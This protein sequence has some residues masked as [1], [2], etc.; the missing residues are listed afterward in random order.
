MKTE[1]VCLDT[2]IL[3]DYLL[4]KKEA[5]TQIQEVQKVDCAT[6]AI[7]IFELFAIAEASE[8][9]EENVAVVQQLID[10]LTI[11]QFN[12]ISCRKAAKLYTELQK[13]KQKVN[14]RDIF[15]GVITKQQNRVLLTLN[16]ENYARIPGLKIYK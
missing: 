10:R 16:K 6:T 5:V 1:K 11:L 4:N 8:K 7:N 3:Q 9:P 13:I 12:S 14:I 2:D 15:V